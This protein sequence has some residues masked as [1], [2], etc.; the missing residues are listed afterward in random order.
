MQ[1]PNFRLLYRG[2]IDDENNEMEVEQEE[3][4][5][6]EIRRGYRR[7][8]GDIARSEENLINPEEEEN[9]EL[10]GFLRQG[11]QLFSQVKGPQE[12]L[13]DAIVVRNLSRICRQKV[14]QMSTN[15]NQFR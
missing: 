13:M 2:M 14:Q 8:I 3:I 12:C 5:K 10:L 11:D 6:A 15:I 9:E 4:T 7:L 1:I